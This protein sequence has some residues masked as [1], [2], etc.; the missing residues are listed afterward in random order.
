VLGT[1]DPDERR[2]LRQLLARALRSVEPVEDE[3][4]YSATTASI[5]T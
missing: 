2:T 4:D 3:L 5:S 1:L